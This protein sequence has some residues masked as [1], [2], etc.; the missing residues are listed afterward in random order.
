MVFRARAATKEIWKPG[1]QSD[2]DL[3]LTRLLWL[4]GEEPGKN[5]GGNVDSHARYIYFHGTNDEDLIGQP[6]SHG[7]IRLRNAAVIEFYDLIPLG[8]KVVIT[9]ED[10]G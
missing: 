8:T 6:A 10:R 9:E 3:V 7:C 5:Q 1:D 4:S 2:E